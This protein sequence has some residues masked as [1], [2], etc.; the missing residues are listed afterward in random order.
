MLLAMAFLD[1]AISSLLDAAD[2]ARHHLVFFALFDM[3]LISTVYVASSFIPA[4]DPQLPTP[5][6]KNIP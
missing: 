5:S 2:I 3:I 1:L 4:S 6:P